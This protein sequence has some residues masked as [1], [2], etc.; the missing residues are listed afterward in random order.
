MWMR[1]NKVTTGEGK[2]AGTEYIAFADDGTGRKNVTLMVRY[3]RQFRPQEP[4]A[5]ITATASGSRGVR[6]HL[7]R[8][9]PEEGLR[10]GVL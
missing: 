4:C 3:R 2:V 6:Q 8:R 10:R 7:H 9:G 5:M 1:R